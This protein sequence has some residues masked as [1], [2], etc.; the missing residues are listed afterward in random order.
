M[1][2]KLL[3][4]LLLVV[5]ACGLLAACTTQPDD[6]NTPFA[7]DITGVN[8]GLETHDLSSEL[9]INSVITLGTLEL[10]Y[11]GENTAAAAINADLR[12]HL[13]AYLTETA[14]QD[15]MLAMENDSLTFTHELIYE[16][17]AIDGQY[18]SII[19]SG[20]DYQ[21]GAAHPNTYLEGFVYDAA[22][23]E[24]LTLA[25]LLPEGYQEELRNSVINQISAAGEENNYYPGYED[26]IDGVIAQ[27]NWY[28]KDNNIYLIFNP[29]QIAPYALGVLEF[30]YPYQ[31]GE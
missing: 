31:S 24:R 20:Y 18:I 1:N 9:G 17:V 15:E 30:P 25:D 29:D 2:K 26:L 13:D 3:L 5:V 19:A 14:D 8:T 10:T 23:G 11:E 22:T 16:P 28:L 21:G 6:T 12:A 7:G 4:G 27:E